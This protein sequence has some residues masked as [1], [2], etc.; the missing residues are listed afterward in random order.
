[1]IHEGR[2]EATAFHDRLQKAGVKGQIHVRPADARRLR[3]HRKMV[4]KGGGGVQGCLNSG[5]DANMIT[6]PS[7]DWDSQTQGRQAIILDLD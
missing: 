6:A 4:F 7:Q 3:M 5:Y 1:M 2:P